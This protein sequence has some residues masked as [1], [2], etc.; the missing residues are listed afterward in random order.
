MLFVP[1]LAWARLRNPELDPVSQKENPLLLALERVGQAAT[2][3]TALVAPVSDSPGVAR[4]AC[5]WASLV[6]MFFYEI[7]WLRYFR[8]DR[9]TANLYRRLGPIPLPLAVLPVLGFALLALYQVHVILL[10]SVLVL[11]IGHVGIHWQHAKRL[12]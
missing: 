6:A 10:G 12:R 8:T 5:L 2:T 4:L 7:A 9:T 1:N 3:M 11:G